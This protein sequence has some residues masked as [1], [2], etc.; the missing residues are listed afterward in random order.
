MTRVIVDPFGAP[1][2]RD[3]TQALLGSSSSPAAE[4]AVMRPASARPPPHSGVN[5]PASWYDA[6]TTARSFATPP[7]GRGSVT[8][9]RPQLHRDQVR[10]RQVHARLAE[11]P[12]SQ[13]ESPLACTASRRQGASSTRFSTCPPCARSR[14]RSSARSRFQARSGTDPDLPQ[15]SLSA[16]LFTSPRCVSWL[17]STALL[18]QSHPASA[19]GDSR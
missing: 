13:T 18:P 15:C 11:V 5:I 17:P 6:S 9:Y 4:F 14:A 7:S 16:R 2:L 19:E 8:T 12:P 3:K 1:V 10:R